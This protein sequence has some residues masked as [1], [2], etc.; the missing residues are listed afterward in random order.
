MESAKYVSLRG[1]SGDIYWRA[2]RPSVASIGQS[3]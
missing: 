1:G 2:R 3:D